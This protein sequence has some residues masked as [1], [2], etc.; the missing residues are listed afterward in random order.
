MLVIW[1]CGYQPDAQR[2]VFRF[3]RRALWSE[4]YLTSYTNLSFWSDLIEMLMLVKDREIIPREAK[5]YSFGLVGLSVCP[6]V[7]HALF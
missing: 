6:S 7:R 3:R 5:G 1:E 4:P 2:Q